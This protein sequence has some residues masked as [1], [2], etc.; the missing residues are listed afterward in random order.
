MGQIVAAYDLMP[1][2]TDIDLDGVIA[3]LPGILPA[4]VKLLETK[5]LPVAFGLMKVNAGFQIDDSD[6]EVGSKLEEALRGI[7]G[8]DN[9]ECTSSTVL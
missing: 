1:E 6:E 8:I 2:S 7:A 3:S 5:I 4:G 9:I